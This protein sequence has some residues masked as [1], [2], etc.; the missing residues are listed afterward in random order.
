MDK[1]KSI[2]NVAVSVGFKVLLIIMGIVV[3]R[4]LISSCGNEV[5]GLNA[6][7]LSILGVLAVA[8]LGVGSAITF[9]MYKPIVNNDLEEVAALYHLFR[10]LYLIIGTIITVAGLLLTPY[11][12][13]LAKDYAD[14]D[15]NLPITFLLMLISVVLSY[16][17]S[18]KT[19]LINAYKNNYI[20]TAI[21]S[22]GIVLQ[23]ILQMITLS[24]TK[25]FVYYLLCR[26]VAVSAQW[27][28]TELL[29]RK[30]YKMIF[31]LKTK[32]REET[33]HTLIRS[34]RAMFVH[35]I[36]AVM[37]S[38]VDSL[39]ISFFVGVVALG[40][41]SNYQNL[42][43]M[44]SQIIALVLSSLTSILGHLY[45]K[46]KRAVVEK[47]C[48]S[49]QLLNYCIGVI[50]Y[51]GYFAIADNLVEILFFKDLVIA[52]SITFVL[53]LN[54][55]IQFM[56]YNTLTFRDATG[57]FYY[58]RWKPLLEGIVNLILSVILVKCIGITGVLVATIITNLVICHIVEPFVLYRYAFEMSPVKYYWNNYMMIIIFF[59]AQLIVENVR[60]G[61]ESSWTELFV[62]GC[63][64]V[65][66]S[67]VTCILGALM[68]ITLCKSILR[69]VRKKDG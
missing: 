42:L 19:S 55:F 35:K 21:T 17:F 62:N 50:F 15:V 31:D 40:A 23:Q 20:T 8:E 10:K 37:V 34:I 13:Y 64:S 22:G 46:E 66:I 16:L 3:K 5:N 69:K 24:Y 53:T 39:V 38:T 29:T 67:A 6:L 60:I 56:R 12:K 25:S 18:A 65:A 59:A 61:A 28:V 49:F 57:T 43:N 32:I 27:C 36:G 9:C 51:L 58:D 33:K 44:V 54:G 26:I 63:I 48:R 41:Y 45:V 2:L 14:L 52:R 30:K 11:I 7:Y 1:K 4:A 68:N 47:Y